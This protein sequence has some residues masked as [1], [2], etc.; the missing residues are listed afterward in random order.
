V[1]KADFVCFEKII[2]ELKAQS[3][4]TAVDW[5]QILNYL[6]AS[7]FR[8]GLLFNFG[9]AATLETKRVII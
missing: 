2:V 9:S 8:V 4:L 1:Y 7:Q 5:G 3:A 6:K